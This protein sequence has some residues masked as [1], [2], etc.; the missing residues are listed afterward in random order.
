MRQDE[1]ARDARK[2][3]DF[4]DAR[5]FRDMALHVCEHRLALAEIARFLADER[6]AF[7]GFQIPKESQAMFWQRFPLETWPGSLENWARF[8]EEWPQLF[9]NMY[10]FWC[11]KV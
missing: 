10:L 2:Y 5:S 9:E 7:C 6:L 3:V 1:Q 8:E 11:Q 4:W